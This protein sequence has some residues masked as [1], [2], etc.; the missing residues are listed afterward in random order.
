MDLLSYFSEH[1]EE[2]AYDIAKALAG[3]DAQNLP[4]DLVKAIVTI[5]VS[6]AQA[7]AL[8]YNSWL[9]SQSKR[10]PE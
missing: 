1:K 6:S 7:V 3:T 9:E 8:Q 10:R 4:P 5:S 2:I